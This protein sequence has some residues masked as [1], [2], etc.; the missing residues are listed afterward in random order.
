MKSAA[1]RV[2]TQKTKY[3]ELLM[4]ALQEFYCKDAKDLF[5]DG[6]VDERAMVGCIYRYMW[7]SLQSMKWDGIEHDIDIEYDRITEDDLGDHR[8]RIV[9]CNDSCC[10]K[11]NDCMK[12]LETEMSSP[13]CVTNLANS[14]ERLYR[15]DILIHNRNSCG[16]A[17]NGLVI[18]FK[19]EGCG[20]RRALVDMAKIYYLTCCKSKSEQYR[21][22]AMVMLRSKIAHVGI[23]ENKSRSVL[24][25]EVSSI[26]YRQMSTE[27]NHSMPW[28]K[29]IIR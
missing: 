19:K 4:Q 16:I 1:K 11:F 7:R 8:K 27:E 28:L 22:G 9:N 23:F 29:S 12:R 17:N 24:G 13:K 3:I 20:N 25:Y 10:D 26:G 15:P 6:M 14:E 5:K 2:M 18:E 21:Y